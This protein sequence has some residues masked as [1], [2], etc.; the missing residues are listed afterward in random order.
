MKVVFITKQGWLILLVACVF[1]I[2]NCLLL[3][4]FLNKASIAENEKLRQLAERYFENDYVRGGRLS[5]LAAAVRVLKKRPTKSRTR[6][7]ESET[8]L[9]DS[10]LPLDEK[11]ERLVLI[12]DAQERTKKSAIKFKV[13]ARTSKEKQS[14]TTVLSSSAANDFVAAIVVIACNRPTVKRC[15]DL[16][17]KY[18]PSAKQFPI[19]VSQDCGH[20]ETADVIASY[21]DQVR[22]VK[23]PDLSNV[24]GVPGNMLSM[25][26]YYKI[27][28]H[29]KWALGQAF[30]HLSYDTVIIVEDDLDIAPDFYEY[31]TA[32]KPLLDKD[33]S[34]WCISAW[35]DNGKEGM[36]HRNDALYRTDFFPG[37]GWM[38]RKSLWDELKPKWP[39]GFWD[40]WMREPAQRKNRACIRPEI[41][42][43]KT[44]GRVGVSHGQFF[45]QHLRFIKLN[46]QVHPFTKTDLSYLLKDNYDEKF[47]KR[48][49]TLPLVTVD[50]LVKKNVFVPEVQVHYSSEQDFQF[51]AKQL[52]AMTD[53]KAGIPR[54]A[55]QGIVSIIFSGVTVH[56]VPSN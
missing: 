19:I 25:M 43:T 20:Q 39:L 37:L 22:H 49:H 2:G 3:Y 27:S 31:F 7:N 55:Y 23:Q 12:K 44:F 17:L 38:L 46:D 45:D 4:R 50:Q 11:K 6:L 42:R 14:V 10:T 21:K 28:R 9:H 24:Q 52:G 15:L 48:I 32:T 53:F 54:M 47:V 18:R 51:V 5:E 26:G 33:P 30:D 8:P 36:V 13:T 41:P 29:Y 34:L 40:D 16:L 56:L 35:N 1:I